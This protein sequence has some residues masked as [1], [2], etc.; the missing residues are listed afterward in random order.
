MVTNKIYSSGNKLAGY[1]IDY[2]KKGF[3][4]IRAYKKL[5]KEG[6]HE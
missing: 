4:G 2:K 5:L 1:S 3:R 6:E